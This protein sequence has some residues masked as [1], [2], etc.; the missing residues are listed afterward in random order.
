MH[1]HVHHYTN[2]SLKVYIGFVI[3]MGN[4][5]N[6][7]KYPPNHPVEPLEGE[8]LEDVDGSKGEK[9]KSYLIKGNINEFGNKKIGF[10]TSR[11]PHF[12]TCLR[13]LKVSFATLLVT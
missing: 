12:S 4:L 11:K 13:Q 2:L 9:E 1:A 8:G 6:I 7:K 5:K 10:S 3:D